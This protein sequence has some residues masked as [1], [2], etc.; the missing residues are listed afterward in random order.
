MMNETTLQ[1]GII[2]RCSDSG[3]LVFHST[4]PRRDI[5]KGFPDLVI[6]GPGGVDFWELK[7]WTEPLSK[8]QTRWKWSLINAGA[9][10]AERRP[11]DLDTGEIDHRL[12]ELATHA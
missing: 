3:L 8:S 10:W 9:N 1:N 11:L 6:C 7:D 2:E 4:D 12:R 5:G